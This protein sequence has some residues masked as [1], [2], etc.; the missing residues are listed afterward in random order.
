M[1]DLPP[2]F[3][4]NRLTIKAAEQGEEVVSERDQDGIALESD[5]DWVLELY[6]INKRRVIDAQAVCPRVTI[7]MKECRCIDV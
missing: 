3:L 2:V 1:L 4:S 7:N 5:I 6:V